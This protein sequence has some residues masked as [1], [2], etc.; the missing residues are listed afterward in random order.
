MNER[1]RAKINEL[2][3]KIDALDE[4]AV[5]TANPDMARVRASTNEITDLLMSLRTDLGLPNVQSITSHQ[6]V[7]GVVDGPVI[8]IQI[9]D[10]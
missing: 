1:L 6:V 8:G 5:G 2:F 4:Y 10:L 9:N 3:N 7:N